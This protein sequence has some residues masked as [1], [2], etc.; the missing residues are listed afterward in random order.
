MDQE[1]R[2]II[3]SEI[4]HWQRSRL[5]P[6]QY[7][8]FLLNLYRESDANGTVDRQR[9]R[10]AIVESNPLIWLLLTGSI[11]L[12]FYVGLNF[13]L[14]P[15]LLQMGLFVASVVAAHVAS[16]VLRNRKPLASYALF[17]LGAGLL[18]AGG[19]YL[20]RGAS[21]EDWGQAAFYVGCCAIVW[22]A[23]GIALRVPWIHLCGWIVLL[24]VYAVA[25]NRAL[26]PEG[27]ASLQASWIPLS[28]LFG[29]TGWLLSRRARQAGA[30]L[31]IVACL[32][33]FAP[34]GY[35]AIWT[36]QD[37]ALTQAIMLGKLIILGGAAFVLRK[38][39]TEWVV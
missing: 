37:A 31:F 8:E 9:R 33:W 27:W 36:E 10:R 29:W 32:L 28:L 22:V 16:G 4:E 24:F 25:V 35:A 3:V 13:S 1:K 38:T 34:E 26:E 11:G 19:A 20:L 39:W 30:V 5:L 21:P 7:C 18:L 17:G 12:F 14:F 23:F 6:D 15:P 2:A